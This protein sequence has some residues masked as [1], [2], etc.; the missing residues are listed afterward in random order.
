VNRARARLLKIME[1]D[2][3]SDTFAAEQ[4]AV[5]AMPD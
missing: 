2:E 4:T 5:A 3:P 1:A